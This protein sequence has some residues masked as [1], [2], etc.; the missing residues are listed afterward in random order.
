M[1]KI[2]MIIALALVFSVNA[3]AK[4]NWIMENSYFMDCEQ[5]LFNGIGEDGRKS[6]EM[7]DCE[8]QQNLQRK[9]P[10]WPL[11]GGRWGGSLILYEN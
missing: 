4:T 5:I 10:T 3:N 9:K 6:L 8:H 7:R 1:N 11:S 2:V